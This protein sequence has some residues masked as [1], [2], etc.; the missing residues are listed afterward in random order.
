MCS[1]N[2]F[3]NIYYNL[4]SGFKEGLTGTEVTWT[5]SWY[6]GK[7]EEQLKTVSFQTSEL[8]LSSTYWNFVEGE[9]PTL[10]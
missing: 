10:K 1:N 7:T 9:F 3:L 4:N 2:G 6:I 8:G 5:A